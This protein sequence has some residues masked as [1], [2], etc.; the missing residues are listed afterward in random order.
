MAGG[1]GGEDEGR[2]RRAGGEPQ[3]NFC[4]GGRQS[5]SGGVGTTAAWLASWNSGKH[6]RDVLGNDYSLFGK[7]MRGLHGPLNDERG[8]TPEI[9][10]PRCALYIDALREPGGP[11]SHT[12]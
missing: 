12:A 4:A 6:R 3:C 7:H 2:E 8:S 9:S 5:R 10:L 11:S 1:A